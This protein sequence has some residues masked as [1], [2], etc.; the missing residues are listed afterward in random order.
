MLKGAAFISTLAFVDLRFGEEGRAR[1]LRALSPED[2]AIVQGIVLPISWYPLQSFINLLRAMDVTLGRADLSLS[3]ERGRFAAIHNITKL[4][5]T[6]LKLI[7]PVW[8]VNKATG[9]WPSHHSSGRWESV[10][11]SPRSA[12][13]TL[14][15]LAIVDDVFCA[16]MRG[17]II[18]LFSI[19]GTKVQVTHSKCRKHGGDACIFD[20]SW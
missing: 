12:T 19:G 17:W 9:I 3:I 10:Q 4:R 18:G 20:A 7:S 1:L 8:I 15:E 11:T 6:L 2:R 14:Y 16:T 5:R 13:A